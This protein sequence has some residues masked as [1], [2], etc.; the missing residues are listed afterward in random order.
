MIPPRS[1]H[2]ASS[3]LDTSHVSGMIT[4]KRLLRDLRRLGCVEVRRKGSHVR[5]DAERARRP[6]PVH[7]GRGPAAGHAPGHPQRPGAMPGRGLVAT[8]HVD[9]GRDESGAWI[10]TVRR[11]ARCA[12]VWPK[13]AAGRASERGRRC[14]SG[15][16]D[17]GDAEL[18]FELHLPREA[19]AALRRASSARRPPSERRR[20]PRRQPMRLPSSLSGNAICHCGMRPSSSASRTSVFNS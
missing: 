11:R 9:I 4:G 5:V 3:G 7:A 13:P 10:A 20:R 16:M 1:A 14:L 18:E 2:D 17:A 8:Y 19:R 15:W 12:H 6:C